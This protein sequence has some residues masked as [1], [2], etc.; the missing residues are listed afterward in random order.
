MEKDFDE[1]E[2]EYL[3]RVKEGKKQNPKDL[4]AKVRAAAELEPLDF[5][6]MGFIRNGLSKWSS[7][8]KRLPKVGLLNRC[9][10]FRAVVEP[11]G[12]LK[13]TKNVER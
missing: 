10:G 5:V 12:T 13:T 8:D 9:R 11:S 6:I 3:E 4:I 7:I 1:Y 2:K